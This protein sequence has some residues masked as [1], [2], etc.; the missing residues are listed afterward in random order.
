MGLYAYEF[1]IDYQEKLCNLGYLELHGVA[2]T[3]Y[4]LRDIDRGCWWSFVY[5]RPLDASELTWEYFTISFLE[6]FMAYSLRDQICNEIDHLENGAITIA[7]YEACFHAK[8]R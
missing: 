8:S 4:Q 2:Y 3:T 7:E 5:C 6:R 1:L